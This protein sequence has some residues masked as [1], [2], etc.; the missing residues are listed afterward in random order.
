MKIVEAS[1]NLTPKEIYNLTMSP[2]TQKMKSVIGQRI[3]FSAW[4]LYEDVSK[5]TGE[6]QEVLSIIT[7]EG[8]IFA[9][10]S[11]TFKGDFYDMITLFRDMGEEVHAITVTSGTSKAGREF[12]T[13]TYS[14]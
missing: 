5:K 8:E 11:P 12:I 7:P 10:N 4:A 9:T 3:E 2:A 1:K 14:D 6:I 13:C